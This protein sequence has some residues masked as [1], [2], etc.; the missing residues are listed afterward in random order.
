MPYFDMGVWIQSEKLPRYAENVGRSIKIS[1]EGK[2]SPVTDQIRENLRYIKKVMESATRFA[3][4]AQHLPEEA[5]WL[6]DNWYIAEREAGY[7]ISDLKRR[8]KIR[9]G[10]NDKPA[11]YTCLLYTS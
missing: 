8:G 10:Q 11:V 5:E 1:G 4:N 3:A 2:V 7:I 6:L 9:W